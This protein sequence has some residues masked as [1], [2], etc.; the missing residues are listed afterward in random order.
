MSKLLQQSTAVITFDLAI[1]SKKEEI[2]WHYPEEFQ[3][4]VIHLGGFHIALS[5]LALIGKMFFKP[6]KTLLFH[7]SINYFGN[8]KMEWIRNQLKR[9]YR[10]LKPT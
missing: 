3:N 4:L 5:Y 9:I 8:E 10:K 7:I 2:H 6:L 1:Y